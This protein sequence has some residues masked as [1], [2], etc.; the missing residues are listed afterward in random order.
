MRVLCIDPDYGRLGFGVVDRNGSRLS[1]VASGLVETSPGP[2]PN[3][4]AQI[5]REIETLCRTHAPTCMATEKLF[6]TKNQTTGIA[7]ACAL[8]CVL[9]VAEERGIPWAEYSPPQVKLGVTGHGG[10]EK[11]QVQYMVTKLLGLAVTPSPDDIADA[12]AVALA[13]ALR[14]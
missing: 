2:L 13:H 8:G 11:K 1:H 12:L 4:L 10:A 9:L 6:F 14:A 5:H 3:R 7:V